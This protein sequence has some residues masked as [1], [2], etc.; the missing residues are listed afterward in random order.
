MTKKILPLL[1]VLL[2]AVLIISGCTDSDRDV[3][4]SDNDG[5]VINE[6]TVD[7]YRI[8]DDETAL[9]SMEIENIGGTTATNVRLNLYGAEGWETAVN[10]IVYSS[11]DPPNINLEPNTPGDFQLADWELQAPD[12]PEGLVVPYNVKGRVRYHYHTTNSVSIPVYEKQEYT[13]RNQIG[14]DIE[15][16]NV[17]N[18]RAPVRV[19]I[20]PLDFIVFDTEDEEQTYSRRLIFIN[21]GSG[22]PIGEIDGEDVDGVITG[23]VKINGPAV[24]ADC[25][26]VTDG[27]EVEIS[28]GDIKIRRSDS[29]K[30]PCSIKI[31][32]EAFGLSPTATVSLIMDLDYDYYVEQSVTVDVAG[33]K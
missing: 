13:R 11:L 1:G 4:T 10:E 21:V 5:I 6:F 22:V 9:F 18:V 33:K 8:N 19:D 26:G 3:K 29:I 28:A 27:K 31:D 24:F 2:V 14:A 12:L 30:K 7:P 25:I 17:V 32:K 16:V 15:S 23:T 20:D